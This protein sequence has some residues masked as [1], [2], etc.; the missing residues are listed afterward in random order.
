MDEPAFLRRAVNDEELAADLDALRAGRFPQWHLV[1]DST[2]R[3]TQHEGGA[4]VLGRF[5]SIWLRDRAGERVAI[6]LRHDKA[7]NTW[8]Q[9]EPGE[10]PASRPARYPA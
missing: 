5:W 2:W 8:Q 4:F 10:K 3:S 7:L 1:A 9:G 6:T